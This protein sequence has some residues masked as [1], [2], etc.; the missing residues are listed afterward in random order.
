[1]EISRG[2]YVLRA[3]GTGQWDVEQYAVQDDAA[4][5]IVALMNSS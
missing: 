2:S 4:E 1:V 3:V 5:R